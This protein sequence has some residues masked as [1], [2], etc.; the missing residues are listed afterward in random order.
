M[1]LYF[2]SPGA[3]LRAVRHRLR[4]RGQRLRAGRPGDFDWDALLDGADLLHLSGITPAL[5]AALGRSRASPRP[6]RRAAKGITVSFDGN[7]R[8]QL[9]QPLGQRSARRSS[10]RL[11]GEAD[12]LF[13]NHRDI[14]LLLGRDFGGEGAERRREAA[15]AAFAA[16]PEPAS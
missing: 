12:I 13:G 8:A 9:W 7:Y 2:L 5:G 3:G 11:V 16:F 14:S 10:T 1:G 4:P 6:R 15:E